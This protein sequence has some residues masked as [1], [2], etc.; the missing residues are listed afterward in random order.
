M[1]NLY[2]QKSLKIRHNYMKSMF[3]ESGCNAASTLIG[4]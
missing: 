2:V 3:N 4:P 1:L